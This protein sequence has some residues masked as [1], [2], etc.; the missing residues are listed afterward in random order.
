LFGAVGMV[1]AIPIWAILTGLINRYAEKHLQ[2]KG[3]PLE[4]SAYAPGKKVEAV[5]KREADETI[6]Q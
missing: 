2:Q 4:D 5:S 3:L 1:F 6:E